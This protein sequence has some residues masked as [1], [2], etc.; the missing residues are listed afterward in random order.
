MEI[1]RL[2]TTR[3]IP[4]MSQATPPPPQSQKQTAPEPPRQR[5]DDVLTDRHFALCER[6]HHLLERRPLAWIVWRR[7]RLDEQ[8]RV[9]DQDRVLG[10]DHRELVQQRALVALAGGV[11]SAPVAV[12]PEHR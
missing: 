8:A 12:E 7:R 4:K 10:A 5:H 1:A 9:V 3:G 2:L 6:G 11:S